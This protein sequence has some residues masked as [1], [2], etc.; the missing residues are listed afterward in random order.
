MHPYKQSGRWQDVLDIKCAFCWSLLR[1]QITM[2]GSGN[3]KDVGKFSFFCGTVQFGRFIR[4]GGT[5]CFFHIRSTVIMQ[6]CAFAIVRTDLR[7]YCY[8]RYRAVVAK[9]MNSW[10]KHGAL[11]SF[12]PLASLVL[13][14]LTHAIFLLVF[15]DTQTASKGCFSWYVCILIKIWQC[16]V[17]RAQMVCVKR[18]LRQKVIRNLCSEPTPW[19]SALLSPIMV[20]GGFLSSF[21]Q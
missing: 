14:T 17:C 9:L 8:M 2:H 4:Y 6:M 3:V 20:P 13:N 12:L 21:H 10:V 11:S 5:Y 15:P 7:A 18:L 16:V 1:G 19:R